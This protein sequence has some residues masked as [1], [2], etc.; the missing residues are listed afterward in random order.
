MLLTSLLGLPTAATQSVNNRSDFES[1]ATA[2]VDTGCG[3]ADAVTTLGSVNEE[4]DHGPEVA[5]TAVCT[6]YVTAAAPTAAYLP[7]SW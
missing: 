6:D 5:T 3:P 1:D 2:T 4:P 7:G